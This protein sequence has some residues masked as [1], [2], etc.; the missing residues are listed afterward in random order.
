MCSVFSYE[1]YFPQPWSKWDPKEVL[2][3]QVILYL[4]C[5]LLAEFW[6]LRAP[7]ID[8][9]PMFRGASSSLLFMCT[10]SALKSSIYI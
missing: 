7:C 5:M 4:Y 8:S 2:Y 1:R 6:I 3:E 9:V 10:F